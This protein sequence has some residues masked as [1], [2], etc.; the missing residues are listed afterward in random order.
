MLVMMM[1]MRERWF[2]LKIPRC[3][4]NEGCEIE[5]TVTSELQQFVVVVDYYIGER[6]KLEGET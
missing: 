4:T 5:V 3:D 1:M 2:V 6:L